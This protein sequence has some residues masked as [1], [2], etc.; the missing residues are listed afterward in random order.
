MKKTLIAIILCTTAA[1][2]SAAALQITARDIENNREAFYT[3]VE[4]EV[5]PQ[6]KSLAPDDSAGS[7]WK[8][9]GKIKSFGAQSL[10]PMFTKYSALEIKGAKNLSSYFSEA[11]T[12]ARI[13][14]IE[15]LHD[16]RKSVPFINDLLANLANTR[17]GD[18]RARTKHNA[19]IAYLKE[20]NA[21]STAKNPT[22][23]EM[24][25]LYPTIGTEVLNPL[26]TCQLWVQFVSEKD[27]PLEV[28]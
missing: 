13:Q 4:T 20:H 7:V 22:I 11:N 14:T 25:A 23:D 26:F 6:I 17:D 15:R 21:L 16:N 8:A 9:W 18:E 27:V 1:I 5:G 24:E 19:A 2:H 10:G 12:K 28:K 3:Y